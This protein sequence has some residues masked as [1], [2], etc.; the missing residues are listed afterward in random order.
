MVQGLENFQKY[1]NG[2]EDR[3]TLIGGVACYLSMKEAA[4]PFRATKDLDIVLCA[5][6]LDREFVQKFWD[7]VHVSASH[8]LI[9]E[10]EKGFDEIPALPE[11]LIKMSS[12]IRKNREKAAKEKEKK[13][14]RS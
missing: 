2:L 11:L 10:Y 3:Y 14:M 12:E 4:L 7:F 6:A 8:V 9:E 13:R 1:F 5:E